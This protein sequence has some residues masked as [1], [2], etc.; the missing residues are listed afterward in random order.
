MGDYRIASNEMSQ[1]CTSAPGKHTV[2]SDICYILVR[3]SGHLATFLVVSQ[4][5]GRESQSLISWYSAECYFDPWV[6]QHH[7]KGPHF[8]YIPLM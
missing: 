6:N 2:R 7:I 8:L 1:L 3:H 4:V 5:T